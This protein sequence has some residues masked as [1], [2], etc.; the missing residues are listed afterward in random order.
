MAKSKRNREIGLSCLIILVVWNNRDGLLYIYH[1]LKALLYWALRMLINLS[2]T[3]LS[4]RQFQ[5]TALSN[6]CQE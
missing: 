1:L 6:E 4:N 5:S 3:P 2:A